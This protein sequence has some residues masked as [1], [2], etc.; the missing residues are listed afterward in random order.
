MSR[1]FEISA[2]SRTH[3][4]ITQ[5]NGML[6]FALMKAILRPYEQRFLWSLD[7]NLLRT[8]A[9]VVDQGGITK[10]AEY[11]GVS[12]PTVSSALKRLEKATGKHLLDRRPRHF[13]LTPAGESLYRESSAIMRTIAQIPSFISAAEHSVSGDISIALISHIAS[14]HFD[15]VLSQFNAAY[16]DVRY[17]V[18]VTDSI[19][20]ASRV[21]QNQATIGLCLMNREMEGV[22]SEPLYR[23]YFGLYCGVAHEL[24]END[25][26]TLSDLSGQ[27]SVSFQTEIED[28]PLHR[29]RKLREQV[30]LHPEPKAVSAHLGELRRLII[31]GV[32]IG[33]LP[34][35]V[36]KRDVELGL[37][38]QLPPYKNLPAVDVHLILSSSRSLDPAEQLF[39]D[40]LRSMIRDSP[41]TE[42]TYK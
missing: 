21:R 15:A 20:V 36:A 14:E 23:E 28:G 33:A 35:H 18:S 11:L 37:L 8:F 25:E 38:R 5:A 13:A 26:V 7:W 30:S 32:G 34:L 16:S 41:L 42:R 10:A 6:L 17:S 39:V 2:N 22:E 31:A 29:I 24:F 3:P 12:Q 1:L 40:M 27:H 19:D 4:A 9:A